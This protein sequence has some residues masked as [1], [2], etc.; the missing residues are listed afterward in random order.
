MSHLFSGSATT[1]AIASP[2]P[3]LH[4]NF[5]SPSPASIAPGT[6]RMNALSTIS[7][8]A[9]EAVSDAKASRKARRNGTP[10]RNT[11]PKVNA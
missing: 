2:T 6:I 7:I 4:Q 9:I 8:T 1:K 5:A 3:R 11:G 10:A